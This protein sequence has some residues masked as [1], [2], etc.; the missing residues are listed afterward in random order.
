MLNLKYN[1]TSD[2]KNNYP[3]DTNYTKM[4]NFSLFEEIDKPLFINNEKVNII[5]KKF[6][7]PVESYQGKKSFII[8]DLKEE[9]VYSYFF[10]DQKGFLKDFSL[11][12][13]KK[14]YKTYIITIKNIPI[15]YTS[16]E[17]Q[18]IL[19]LKQ[20][21][22]DLPEEMLVNIKEIILN[23]EKS[24][25]EASAITS[26]DKITCY[27][28]SNYSLK[29]IKNIIIHEI[30]HTWGHKL[31]EKKILDYHYTQYKEYAKKDK[32]FPSDYAKKCV[33]NKDDYA[34]DFAEAIAFY[35]I[36][37]KKFKKDFPNRLVYIEKLFQ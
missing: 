2:K 30:A 29:K 23:P 33:K 19:K 1:I 26:Y 21:I 37:L 27:K 10:S 8:S 28:L 4:I 6:S 5:N 31:R 15:I 34:E 12:N 18:I 7:I 11:E 14:K 9:I 20:I 17:K 32:K 16:K 24:P 25:S 3:I 35:F 22:E 36:D 13:L